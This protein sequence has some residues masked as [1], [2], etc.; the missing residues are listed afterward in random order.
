MA[1]WTPYFATVVAIVTESG[2]LLSHA[3]VVAREYFIPA[4]LGVT[5]ATTLLQDGQPV[6]VDGNQGVVRI[7]P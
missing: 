2:G 7:L 6:E 3:A 1:A 4:V 5:M